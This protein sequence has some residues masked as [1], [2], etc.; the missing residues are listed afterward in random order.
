MMDAP[1]LSVDDIDIDIT[2]KRNTGS[3]VKGGIGRG[4][5]RVRGMEGG[6]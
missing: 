1:D 5:S 3:W 2:V 4:E 6:D